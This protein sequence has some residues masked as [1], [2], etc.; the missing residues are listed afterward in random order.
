[1]RRERERDTYLIYTI[2]FY[3]L[4]L[5]NNYIFF[6]PLFFLGMFFTGASP[7]GGASNIWTVLLGGNLDLSI[8]MSA[9]SN[10]AS[11]G[12]FFFASNN[13]L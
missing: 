3:I 8:A 11:F 2:H 13:Y 12:K 6:D 10:I 9:I 7:A 5:Y 4:H 1:M